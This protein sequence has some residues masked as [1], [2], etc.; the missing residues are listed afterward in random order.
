[1]EHHDHFLS[2]YASTLFL[3]SHHML[4]SPPLPIHHSNSIL[5]LFKHHSNTKTTPPT[6]TPPPPSPPFSE[7][8]EEGGWCRWR[9]VVG[10]HGR[11]VRGAQGQRGGGGGLAGSVRC[12]PFLLAP[13][14][15]AAS[16]HSQRGRRGYQDGLRGG[17]ESGGGGLRAGQQHAQLACG[18]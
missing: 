7:K 5:A 8:R 15:R 2:N 16:S 10:H 17:A 1:L 18:V 14:R 11:C 3:D 6:P 9:G 12:C 4:F 13:H